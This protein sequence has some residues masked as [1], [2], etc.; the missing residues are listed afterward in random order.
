[1]F[2]KL[3]FDSPVDHRLASCLLGVAAVVLVGILARRVAGDRAGL[4]AA[5]LAAVYPQLWIND[6][7][8]I[9]ESMY[10]VFI[11]LTLLCAYRLWD[12]DKW[13]DAALLGAMIALSALTPP[14]GRHPRSA[15]RHPVPLRPAPAVPAA[16]SARSS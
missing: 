2:S 5:G 11:A 15:A 13:T 8:L 1:M 6:G 4:I 12:S 3:G 10:V 14:R 16:V 7:M 9:S